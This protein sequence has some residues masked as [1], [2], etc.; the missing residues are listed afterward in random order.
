MQEL[1][2]IWSPNGIKWY[3]Y[4]L[5]NKIIEVPFEIIDIIFQKLYKIQDKQYFIN[6]SHCEFSGSLGSFHHNHLCTMIGPKIPDTDDIINI[7]YNKIHKMIWIDLYMM[8]RVQI[9][10]IWIDVEYIINKDTGALLWKDNH[11]VYY[12]N[13][14]QSIRNRILMIKKNYINSFL[15]AVLKSLNKNIQL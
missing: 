9:D 7:I 11:Y 5:F 13:D 4:F 15:G 14:Y 8:E 10:K 1:T 12:Y 3:L 6:F 2:E